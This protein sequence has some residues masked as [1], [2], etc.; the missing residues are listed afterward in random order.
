M[1]NDCPG[2]QTRSCRKN[3]GR[4]VSSRITTAVTS[5]TGAASSSRAEATATSNRR[6]M[7]ARVGPWVKPSP[8]TSQPV[9][10]YCRRISPSSCS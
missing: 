3:I 9:R 8:Y 6:L 7:M 5:I 4:P 10:R 1:S 2:A